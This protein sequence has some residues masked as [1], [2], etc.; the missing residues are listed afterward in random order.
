MERARTAFLIP[1]TVAPAA[2]A[3]ALFVGWTLHQVKAIGPVFPPM[4]A[5]ILVLAAVIGGWW[6]SRSIKD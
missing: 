6:A 3:S 2:I 1:L 4:V 5:L